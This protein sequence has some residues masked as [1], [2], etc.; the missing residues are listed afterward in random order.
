MVTWGQRE[1]RA[2]AANRWEELW[3]GRIALKSDCGSGC[4]ILNV[5]KTRNCTLKV[6]KFNGM[7]IIPQ[8]RCFF[9]EAK[10]WA[11]PLHSTFLCHWNQRW[12][13]CFQ[14][15]QTF[16]ARGF[17]Q[18]EGKPQF[19][20]WSSPGKAMRRTETYL[21]GGPL[22]PCRVHPTWSSIGQMV[23]CMTCTETSR[24]DV[25]QIMC[26]MCK[27]SDRMHILSQQ[28]L[29]ASLLDL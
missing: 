28:Y 13:W 5:L 25:K 23:T 10:K 7:Y 24:N 14:C 11:T 22:G 20:V 9:K 16:Y 19:Q 17:K 1:E 2:M 27:H 6:G 12:N 26:F 8:Y 4:A 29:Q 18:N 15:M 3:E 21:A